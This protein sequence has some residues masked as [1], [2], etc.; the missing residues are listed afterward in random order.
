MLPTVNLTTSARRIAP[1]SSMRRMSAVCRS[2]RKFRLFAGCQQRAQVCDRHDRDGLVGHGWRA[3]R[4]H[5]VGVDEPV[6]DGPA[7]E[8][9][10]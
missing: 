4:A 2:W 5:R 6:A 1:G 9:P 3:H 7:V 10:Q 8:L